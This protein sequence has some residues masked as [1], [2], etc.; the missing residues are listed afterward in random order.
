MRI[1]E[2]QSFPEDE[3]LSRLRRV[4]LRGHGHPLIYQDAALQIAPAMATD[5]LSPAQTYV[6]KSGVARTKAL[7]AA[8]LAHQGV[9]I[10]QLRGGLM[11][12]TADHPEELIPVIPP[13]VE[14]SREADGREI[15]LI[16]D[17]MHR[18]YSARSMD[19]PIHV[20]IAR[21]VPAPFPYYAFPLAQGWADVREVDV[22]PE[23]F[24]KKAY[25][26]P[27]DHKALF[28]DFN[29]V[30]PG[31]QAKRAPAKRDDTAA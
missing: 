31:V 19:L 24:E 25:R 28:R 22:I 21:G 11:V 8:L 29:A 15:L 7:R 30:F 17:G 4:R 13:V 6:L 3:L 2:C 16:N 20:V 14:V 23:T 12:R 9:D 26:E 18:I 10:F 5:D 1:L 27:D